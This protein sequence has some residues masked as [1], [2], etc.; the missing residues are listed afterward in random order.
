[1]KSQLYDYLESKNKLPMYDHYH[2]KC[3]EENICSLFDIKHLLIIYTKQ[4]TIPNYLPINEYPENFLQKYNQS[5]NLIQELYRL[6]TF[7]EN[8]MR[9]KNIPKSNNNMIIPRKYN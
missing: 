1:M 6:G 5:K 9:H 3:E 8:F 2:K 4:K 7:H